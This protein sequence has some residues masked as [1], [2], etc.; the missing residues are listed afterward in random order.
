MI[1]NLI[2]ASRGEWDVTLRAQL[3]RTGLALER[4]CEGVEDEE[5]VRK[6]RDVSQLLIEAGDAL[7]EVHAECNRI[8][9][10]V[11]AGD[12]PVAKA[13]RD[14]AKTINRKARGKHAYV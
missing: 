8:L 12:T 3:E 10:K 6:A 2:R 13:L 5:Q 1:A 11:G 7:G 4:A 14:V 9:E